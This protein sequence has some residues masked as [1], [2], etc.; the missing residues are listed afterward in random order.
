VATKRARSASSAASF[1]RASC[2]R[3]AARRLCSIATATSFPRDLVKLCTAHDKRTKT[4]RA[5]Q[6]SDLLEKRREI[7]ERWLDFVTRARS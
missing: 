3:S 1:Q 4:D 2:S 5:Y 6:R 7:M